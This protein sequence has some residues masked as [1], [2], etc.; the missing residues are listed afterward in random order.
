M[1][2]IW[3]SAQKEGH[4]RRIDGRFGHKQTLGNG[5]TSACVK[6]LAC[7]ITRIRFFENASGL[8]PVC[9][10]LLKRQ[11]IPLTSLSR[12]KIAAI[13]MD[14]ASKLIDRIDDGMNDVRAQRL[15]VHC[16]KGLRT[17]SL[18]LVRG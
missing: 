12:E 2:A 3:A 16:T 4:L 6:V 7:L 15:S 18:D 9:P 14:G 17:R 13:E 11:G 10:M 1:V 5:R 8:L